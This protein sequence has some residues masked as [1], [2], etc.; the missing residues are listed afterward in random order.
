MREP[1][2]GAPPL[3][4]LAVLVGACHGSGGGVILN[5][6]GIRG[7]CIKPRPIH[8]DT[9]GTGDQITLR[10]GSPGAVQVLTLTWVV[11]YGAPPIGAR[12]WRNVGR[13]RAWIGFFT[14]AVVALAGVGLSPIDRADAERSGVSRQSGEDT[15]AAP[16]ADG[17]GPDGT[18]RAGPGAPGGIRGTV[19]TEDGGGPIEG[20]CV[21]ADGIEGTGGGIAVTDAAGRYVMGD[22]PADD[23]RVAFNLCAS[24]DHVPEFH[25]DSPDA[26]AAT[27]VTVAADAF[28][29]DVDA[30][31]APASPA[32]PPPVGATS[33]HDASIVDDAAPLQATGAAHIT[34]TVTADDSNLPLEGICVYAYDPETDVYGSATT[35]P[36]G[37]YDIGGL[38]GVMPQGVV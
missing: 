35:G 16:I 3:V 33:D 20:L 22:L 17:A 2:G 25:G 6:P 13:G 12:G 10:L 38:G 37:A 4:V 11:Q 31:L 15:E 21:T 26:E 8:A 14:F 34:G 5:Q 18:G 32:A 7:A 30:V 27:P 28:T 29:G 9:Q 1:K 36:D 23:Y 19:T 24:T